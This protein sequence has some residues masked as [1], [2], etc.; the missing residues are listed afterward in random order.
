MGKNVVGLQNGTVWKTVWQC[1]RQLEQ[2]L[3]AA[4][5]SVLNRSKLFLDNGL[6]DLMGMVKEHLKFLCV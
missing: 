3:E 2:C 1:L 6:S 5:G 4:R